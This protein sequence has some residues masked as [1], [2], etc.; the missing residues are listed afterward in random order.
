MKKVKYLLGNMGFSNKTEI[1]QLY[2]DILDSYEN[3]S[4]PNREDQ[5]KIWHL[6]KHHDDYETKKGVGVKHFE[7]RIGPP[8]EFQNK[9]FYVIRK[10]DTFDD[11]SYP[12]CVGKIKKIDNKLEL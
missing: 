11:F 8:Y 10:D 4:I 7:I 9:C 5:I 12:H 3:N 6:F 1:K 2:R